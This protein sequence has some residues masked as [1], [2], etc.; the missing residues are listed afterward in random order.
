MLCIRN[1]FVQHTLYEVIR[2]LFN[3]LLD[4]A[5]IHSIKRNVLEDTNRRPLTYKKLITACFVLGGAIKKITEGDKYVGLML[6]NVNASAVTFFAM[7]AFGITPAMINFTSG[8]S[9]VISS[10]KTS[11]LKH[12]ITSRDF[13]EKANLSE[14]ITHIEDEGIELVYLEDV[15]A[16]LS[17]SYNFV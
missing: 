9:S 13:I 2:T 8:I 7:Q 17:I 3:S 1:N 10:C 4:S 5:H 16:E 11:V 6:P 14:L 15:K 12:V